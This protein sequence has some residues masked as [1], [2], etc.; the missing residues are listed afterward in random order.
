MVSAEEKSPVKVVKSISF[1]SKTATA[2][3]ELNVPAWVR[4]RIGRKDGPLYRTIVDW[5]EKPA[6]KYT[7]IWDG[8]D[9]SGK[10]KLVGQEE[11]V[12]T[13]GYF[14][15]GDEYLNNPD[16]NEIMPSPESM[17]IGRHLPALEIN[18][19]HKE[20]N[21]KFCHEP[22]IKIILPEEIKLNENNIIIIDK[23]MPL[24]FII[25]EED[26]KWFTRERF[27]IHCFIDGV[28]VGGQLE[29]YSPYNWL[30]DPTHINEGMHLLTVNFSG[31]EDHIGISS[32]PI[33]VVRG[34]VNEKAQ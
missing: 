15:E 13:F 33:Y 31:F 11:L 2:A 24:R 9:K 12:F 4:V 32:L 5:E 3:Y 7:E 17:R 14:T 28:F 20:H 22:K 34:K 6:G 26:K 16:L 8:F 19:I 1:D 10:V 29:G 21:R 18:K 25:E 23:K 30:F 27:S